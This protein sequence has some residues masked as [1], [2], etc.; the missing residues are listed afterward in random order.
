MCVG[1]SP[2][3]SVSSTRRQRLSYKKVLKLYSTVFCS[4]LR[5][6]GIPEQ[7]KRDQRRSTQG[8]KLSIPI[9]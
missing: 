6:G 4:D 7:Q 5:K 3:N 2:S 1:G 9:I 8:T